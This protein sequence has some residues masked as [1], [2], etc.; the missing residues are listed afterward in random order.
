MVLSATSE[1][2]DY[3][4]SNI[5]NRLETNYWQSAITTTQYI[6][7]T[8]TGGT[9]TDVDYLVLYGHNL[10]TAGATV[11]LQYSSDNFVADVNDAFT[12]EIPD[13]DTIYYKEF[14]QI[15]ADYWRIKITGATVAPS[16]T[17]GYWGELTELDWCSTG[18]DPNAQ[19]IRDDVNRSETGYQLGVYE[20]YTERT[21][22]LTFRAAELDVYDKVEAWFNEVGRQNF[23]T[24]WDT[25]DHPTEV[26]L[27]YSDGVLN[28]PYTTN[29][30][31]RDISM[32]LTGRK[33]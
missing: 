12:G 20:T 9:G 7:D 23:F 1:L 30:L 27:M 21:Q 13:S 10:L 28:A 18:F 11:T 29:G 6:T 17:I 3:P 8:G 19:N 5:I 16:I 14:D 32:N 2:S 25:E 24:A 31:Y 4:V 26:F 33:A 15:N 22:S